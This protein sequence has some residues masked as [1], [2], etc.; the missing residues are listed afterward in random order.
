MVTVLIYF[1]RFPSQTWCQWTRSWRTHRIR[2]TLKSRALFV[3]LWR[4]LHSSMLL[5]W[6][7]RLNVILWS[8]CAFRTVLTQ[9]ALISVKGVSL[10]SYLEGLMAKTISV[11]ANKVLRDWLGLGGPTG[12]APETPRTSP[13]SLYS[14]KRCSAS[15]CLR[16]GRPWNGSSDDWTQKS[17]SWQQQRVERCGSPWPPPLQTNDRVLI[18]W[19]SRTFPHTWRVSGAWQPQ[20]RPPA[21]PPSLCECCWSC[22]LR[23]PSAVGANQAAVVDAAGKNWA[24]G[25]LKKNNHNRT[26]P[27]HSKLI[28]LLKSHGASMSSLLSVF[29]PLLLQLDAVNGQMKPHPTNLCGLTGLVLDPRTDQI[30]KLLALTLRWLIED[31]FRSMLK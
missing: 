19:T 4:R 5:R 20:S 15:V 3:S 26:G 1:L 22:P 11:N 10:S 21:P 24:G 8:L 14:S 25:G 7:K 29:S 9:E 16:V 31:C 2:R 13:L 17:K 6:M 18:Q 28:R 12:A 30:S 23:P 27:S